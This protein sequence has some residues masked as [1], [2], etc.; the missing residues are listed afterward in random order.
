MR[1]RL[2]VLLVLV[3]GTTAF[4]PAPLPKPPRRGGTNDV[5]IAS[6]QGDWRVTS[7]DTIGPNNQK[8]NVKWFQ[9]VRFKDNQI[10]YLLEGNKEYTPFR[11]AL[12]AAKRP[13]TI[14]LFQG[15]A[16]NPVMFGIV[17]RMGNRFSILYYSAGGQ[18]ATSFENAPTGWWLLELEK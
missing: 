5:S 17:R 1:A 11:I 10:I 16:Q 2:I 18:R 6:I 4:A 3:S 12:D 8:T 13:A 15:E 9:G 7:F 14:D